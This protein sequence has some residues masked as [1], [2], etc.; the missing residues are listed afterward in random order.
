MKLLAWD[1]SV[2]L[3]TIVAWQDGR[4][5]AELSCGV[6]TSHSD[7]LLWGIHQCLAAVHWQL[8]DLDGIGVG[9]GPGSFTGLRIGILTAK[10]LG[11]ARG[12]PV[13]GIPSLQ[14]PMVGLREMADAI[15]P[16]AWILS[17]SEGGRGQYHAQW[18]NPQSP[19]VAPA[20][21]A[22]PAEIVQVSLNLRAADADAPLWV[23]GSGGAVV[24]Q[25]WPPELLAPVVWGARW[26]V[27]SGRDLGQLAERAFRAD[28]GDSVISEVVP[29]YG[30]LAEPEVR[31][32]ARQALERAAQGIHP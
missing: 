24:A 2:N 29:I 23:V 14:I 10:A 28:R 32:R 12:T 30:R 17:L 18:S 25:A 1:S 16:T 7:H 27:A 15:A 4:L 21:C 11:Y 3:A 19:D 22:S 26:S 6:H 9:Q 13:R 31:L 5:M 20:R 8:E